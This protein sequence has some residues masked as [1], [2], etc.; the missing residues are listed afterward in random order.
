MKDKLTR[1]ER[2]EL[3]ARVRGIGNKSTELA[4][5][6]LFRQSKITGWRRQVQIGG[7]DGPLGRPRP[8][9]S[10]GRNGR[11]KTRIPAIRGRRLTLRSATGTARRAVPTFRVRPDFIFPKL[12]L[13]VFVDGCFWHG[14]PRHATQPKSNRAFWKNKFAR[15]LARDKLVNRTLRREGW[16]VIRIWECALKKNPLNCLRRIQRVWL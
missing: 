6:K 8:Q 1:L 10:E 9:R 7:R 16:R 14:C 13:A 2:S 11:G 4:L 12:R 5:A 15:N 3:M